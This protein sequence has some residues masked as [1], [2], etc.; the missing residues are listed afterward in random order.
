M[1]RA[2]LEQI[3]LTKSEINVYL[4]LLELGSSATGRIVDRSKASSSKIYEILDRLIQKG[5]VSFIIKSGVKF[6]E[7]AP[8]ERIMDYMNEKEKALNRQKQELREILPELEL[9]RKLSKYKSEAT[10]YKGMKG[11]ETAYYGALKLLKPNEETLVIA[12]PSRPETINRFI[13]KFNRERARR[14]V[15]LRAIWNESAR[16][17]ARTL[18]ENNPLSE[19]K[20][21]S[22]TTSASIEIFKNRVLIFPKTE[23]P[24]VI[25]IDSQEVAD[26]FRVQFEMWWN[27]DVLVG[28]G[29]DT[30]HDTFNKMLDELNPGEE[31]LVLGA[32]WHG[33]KQVVYDF[34]ID[35][36][37][38]RV[39]K[40][41]RAKFLFVSGTERRVR[42]HKESYLK[43]GK[44][45]Y[46]PYEIYEGI[47]INLYNSKVLI[48]VW[49]EKEPVVFTIKDSKVYQ[50]FKNYFD[51]LWGQDTRIVRGLDA[52]QDIYE[53]MTES[54]H[55][56]FIAARGY[57]VGSKPKYIDKWEKR[58]I[59]KGFTMRNIVDKET[60]GHRITTFPF[61]QT[62]YTIPKEYSKL[63][64]FWIYGN[65]VV[66]SNWVEKEPIAVIIE[67]KHL[68]DMYKQQFE[69]LWKKDIRL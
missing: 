53:E 5:L 7:A 28:K 66:I 54:G 37:R 26:S 1:D 42:E 16:G 49:R 21:I 23:D 22:Q 40:K 17:E 38:R 43:L 45:K 32:S 13:V 6:F 36:H 20:Y 8:P 48:F 44:V 68:H 55:C 10:I 3:G 60:K 46:L 47:Q 2:I 50:T 25:S 58:A 27:Q 19:V 41:V 33:Q 35:F 51:N 4:A 18:P 56:D 12:G 61:A 24:L 57:F 31:Y 29:I 67:N 62:K 34:F 65:K 15:K 63:S 52:I 64:V 14:K 11:L 39:K 9:K 69:L 59:K 30:L